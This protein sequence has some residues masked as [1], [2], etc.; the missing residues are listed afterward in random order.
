MMNGLKRHLNTPWRAT[1]AAVLAI[2]A[3]Q[4]LGATRLGL[5]VDEAHYALYGRFPALSYFDHPPMVGWIQWFMLR[6]GDSEFVLRL[7]PIA[8]LVGS[9]LA[10]HR[11]ARELYPQ[12]SPW[13]ATLAVL[14]FQSCIMV[15]LIGIGMVPDGPLLLFGLL[16]MIV[17][18]R[19][20]RGAGGREWLVLGLLL[21]LAALSKYTAITLAVS[22]ALVV[23]LFGRWRELARPWVWIGAAIAL[24][25]CAPILVW[26][27]QNDWI[28]IRYQ[29]EH[30]TGSLTW[31]LEKFLV[32]QLSQ[33]GVYAPGVYLF[34]WLAIV[35][36]LRA[37]ARD[38]GD[39]LTLLFALPILLLFGHTGGYSRGLPH[40]PLLGWAALMPML[41]GYV[42]DRWPRSRPTR[43]LARFTLATSA[44]IL[45]ALHLLVHL[46]VNPFPP[47]LNPL[48]DL[49]GWDEAAAR[50]V[51]LRR[52]M[53]ADQP[54]TNPAVLV[55]RW[56]HASRLA[57]YGRPEPM[58]LLTD[59]N[60]QFIY[61]YG[62]P[63]AGQNG[64]LVLWSRKQQTPDEAVR[65]ELDRFE[66]CNWIETLTVQRGGKPVS[67]FHF[68]Q[69]LGLRQED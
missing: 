26:N 58:L 14:V 18:T 67:S 42:A 37:R 46:P 69:C 11:L 52:E 40:W 34:G 68:Y 4:L 48:R 41:V 55:R 57:W 38:A 24:A 56:N 2:A 29:M 36:A 59:R 7:A 19:I 39:R 12:R 35:A 20:A 30:G 1:L 49:I 64:I 6:L 51:A 22:A 54:G 10:L 66:Q 60:R 27:L 47:Y 43:A 13:Q 25:M 33:A 53:A 15:H 44:A 23:A 3:L 9:S 50:A 65:R 17:L 32:T 61:W 5:G 16:A 28:S 21:G 8:L 62:Q 63:T 45:L 31:S